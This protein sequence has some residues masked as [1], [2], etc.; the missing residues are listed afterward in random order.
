MTTPPPISAKSGSGGPPAKPGT[1]VDSHVQKRHAAQDHDDE[2][3]EEG[4]GAWLVS[5]AD[6]MTLLM[7]FFAL[8]FT[9]VQKDQTDATSPQKQQDNIEQMKNS[10]TEYFGGKVEKAF[11]KLKQQLEQMIRE[12]GLEQKVRIDQTSS[13]LSLVFVGSAFFEDGSTKIRPELMPVVE[14]LT[15]ALAK[16][17]KDNPIYVEGH[18]DNRPISTAYY[19]SNWELSSARAGTIV[20]SLEQKGVA[21]NRLLIQGFGDSQPL[22]PNL[23]EKGNSI[24]E[25]QAKNRRVVIHLIKI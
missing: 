21:K 4:E 12:N 24:P 23:D 3:K 1:G 8:M 20:R 15:G 18:T 25:N 10:L 16:E 7:A 6:M 9:L 13:S 11:D 2:H 17:V 14:K 19:P 22:A 5:Y